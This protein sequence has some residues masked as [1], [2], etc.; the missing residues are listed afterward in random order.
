MFITPNPGVAVALI[1]EALRA[2]ML[3]EPRATVAVLARYADQADTYYE[4][5]RR[6]EVP[7]LR[8][9]RANDFAFRAGVEVVEIKQVKGLEYD[10]VMLVDA[11]A[12]T[13]PKDD[14]SRH[15]IHVAAT[16]A[17]HQLWFVASHTPSAI[18]PQWLVDA[19]L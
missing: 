15:L 1:A 6:S 7:S 9:I 14:E 3:R 11:N 18:L 10:Y 5:L 4:G 19:A 13:F 8:R 12:S 17:A 2:L 16:R